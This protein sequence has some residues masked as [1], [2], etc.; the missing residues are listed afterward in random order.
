MSR[1]SCF[2]STAGRCRAAFEQALKERGFWLAKGD[3]RGFV[4]VDY[5]GE[6]YA[7]AG[8]SGVKTKEVEARL[9]DPEALPS[10]AQVKAEIAA[11]MTA[12]LQG[13][14][15]DVERDAAK[16]SLQ[17]DFRKAEIV[18]RHQQER[19]LL[20]EAHEKRWRA[21]TQARAARLP[22]GFAGIALKRTS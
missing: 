6:V 15:R 10:V 7:I 22:K 11:G 3:R 18:A 8:Y 4:A 1:A 20:T 19:R 14:I 12:R 16:R 5:R 21:E 13:F 17:I 9:G 2:L